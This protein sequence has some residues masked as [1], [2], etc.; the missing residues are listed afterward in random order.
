[1]KSALLA[2]A[3][4]LAFGLVDPALAAP[5]DRTC[6]LDV[7]NRYIA[8][9]SAHDPGRAPL[10]TGLVTIE[11]LKRI[12]PGEGMWSLIAA[13]PTDFVI[14]VPDPVSQ[15]VGT[16]ALFTGT[17]GKPFLAGIRLKLVDGKIAEAEHL[18]ANALN[19]DQ[20]AHLQH[21][22][23]ALLMPVTDEYRDSRD[24]M[25]AIGRS[26]YDALDDNN[27]ALAPFA[28]DCVRMENGFQTAR[29]DPG[30]EVVTPTPDPGFTRLAALGCAAQMDTGMWAYIDTIDNRRVEIADP[31]T[32]LVWGMSHFHHDMKETELPIHGV[33]GVPVRDMRR[34]TR[35]FDVPA[36]H[37]Y[38][39][40]GGHIHE[41]EA[42]G[43]TTDY[44][45]PTGW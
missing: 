36:I 42:I 43:R 37:I 35:P 30:L 33:M 19:D 5:C 44:M 12:Q 31:V 11:N 27:G 20:I 22:R 34:F 26:Y 28:D 17:D 2:L 21:P 39:I 32:G 3:L 6:L 18:I 25:L 38:K 13:P 14:Q 9:L 8:A 16:M 41:I 4:S 1:M 23:P 15:Q 10:A 40:W 45:S 29:N 7:A 24:R